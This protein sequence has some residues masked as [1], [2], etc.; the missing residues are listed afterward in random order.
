MHS[1]F[2]VAMA[3]AIVAAASFVLHA[4]VTPRSQASEIQLR[5]GDLLYSEGR[6]S[7]A[8]EAYRNALKTAPSENVRAS[9][10]GVISSALRVAEFD[11]ARKEAEKLS[12]SDPNS[13]D[14]LSLYG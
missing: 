14:A 7:D 1:R 2:R 6:Y 8:L 9:R 3:S 11:V 4:D 13:P 12:E 10:F 5:L